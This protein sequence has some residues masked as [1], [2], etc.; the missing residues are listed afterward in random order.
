MSPVRRARGA[1]GPPCPGVR[2]AQLARLVHVA[3]RVRTMRLAAWLVLA[4]ATLTGCGPPPVPVDKGASRTILLL[5]CRTFGGSTRV[6]TLLDD[7]AAATDVLGPTH[8][9]VEA[10]PGCAPADLPVL[11]GRHPEASIAIAIVGDL[12][13]LDGVDPS[14]P[15]AALERLTS[16]QVPMDALRE[17]LGRLEQTARSQGTTLLLATAPLGRQA[18]LEVPELDAVAE[19]V[20]ERGAALDLA[21]DFRALE[22]AP[23]F[24]NG[25]DRLDD[26]GHDELAAALYACCLQDG[27]P[28]PARDAAETSARLQARA[29]EAFH[30]DREADFAQLAAQALA[31]GEAPAS[32]R[33]AA[34]LAALA[35]AR[36]GFAAA[37]PRWAAIAGPEESVPGLALGR[38]LLRAAH[39]GAEPGAQSDPP[40]GREASGTVDSRD[41]A[42]SGA[43]SPLAGEPCDA[44]PRAFE[45]ELVEALEGLRSADGHAA[46]LAERCV[47]AHPERLEAWIALQV[48]SLALPPVRDMRG[49]ARRHLA[50]CPRDTVPESLLTR[51]LRSWPLAVDDLP[52]L[53]LASRVREG[54]LP[55]G[56]LLQTAR[57]RASL[58]YVD[59]ALEMLRTGLQGLRVPPAWERELQ[60]IE[61]LPRG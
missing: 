16:R 42:V 48:V 33:H 14:Q 34:R 22:P 1:L 26:F 39:Y 21:R 18:R 15:P 49:E 30:A 37:A 54:M 44:S 59:H 5:G 4:A 55:T 38:A 13:V 24:S 35:G 25:I 8:F 28:L 31:S 7:I 27:G 57:R 11:L 17:M 23:L 12:S 9:L 36:E 50:L 58:G 41:A 43:A 53:L 19:L 6:A 3:R 52:A 32:P 20:R 29:L 61:A 51:V 46:E 56:P 45:A 47:R 10:P 2:F 40:P 60:R